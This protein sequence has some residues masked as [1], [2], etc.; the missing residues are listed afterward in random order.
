MNNSE[1][2][3]KLY[4]ICNNYKT[5]YVTGGLG[6]PLNSENKQYFINSYSDNA[7]RKD[8]INNAS[9]DTF[10]FD[11][12]GLIKA[13]IWGWN[14]NINSYRG[15]ANYNSNGLLDVSTESMI[16]DYCTDIT[17][18]FSKSTDGEMVYIPGHVGVIVNSKQKLVIECTPAWQ[19]K[20]Q[21]SSYD[22]NSK[23][24]YRKWN[25]KGKL[26]MIEYVNTNISHITDSSVRLGTKG[27]GTYIAQSLL[28][29]WGYDI[30]KCGIDGSCGNDTVNAIKAFQKDNGLTIDG[31]C[32]KLTWS[33]LCL[34]M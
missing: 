19:G 1:F 3:S 2:V 4:D 5:L 10:A 15:G 8:K 30:G 20:M 27:P 28:T 24:P 23:Y 34:I 9:N 29:A 32:G 16:N 12:S 18:D 21:I 7:K 13:V 26:K 33:K 25:K 11:C 14:G 17:T 22:T 31:S 6:N